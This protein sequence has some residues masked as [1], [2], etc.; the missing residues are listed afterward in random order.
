MGAWLIGEGG[1]LKG[2]VT[3]VP[4]VLVYN[5]RREEGN[6]KKGWCVVAVMDG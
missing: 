6:R 5:N 3:V 4:V 1:R 2:K